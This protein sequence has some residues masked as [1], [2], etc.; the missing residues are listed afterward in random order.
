[1]SFE[2]RSTWDT[3]TL[4]VPPSVRQGMI[5]KEGMK[6]GIE[7]RWGGKKRKGKKSEMSIK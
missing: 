4:T 3:V 1:M 2:A 6:V 5:G 7:G